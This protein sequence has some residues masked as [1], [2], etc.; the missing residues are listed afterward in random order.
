MTRGFRCES[1]GERF[2]EDEAGRYRDHHGVVDPFPVYE[3]FLR[4]PYCYGEDLE[5]IKLTNEEDDDERDEES[6]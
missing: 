3:T 5:E 1:C 4:C 6:D 2:S